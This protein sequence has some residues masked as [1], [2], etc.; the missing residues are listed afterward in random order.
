M[1]EYLRTVFYFIILGT[2]TVLQLKVPVFTSETFA[3]RL[4]FYL[5]FPKHVSRY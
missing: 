4:G 5:S 3:S 2:P 1:T